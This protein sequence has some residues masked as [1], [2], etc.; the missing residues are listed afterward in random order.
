DLALDQRQA[1]AS[2]LD[3]AIA[4][5]AKAILARG[6]GLPDPDRQKV[7][8]QFLAITKKTGDAEAGKVIFKNNCAKCHKHSG[9][10]ENIGPDLTGVAVHTKEHLLVDI[11]DP[12]RNVEGNFRVWRVE[13][14]DGRSFSGMLAAETK[15]SVELV[16]AEAKRH[17][18][19]RSDIEEL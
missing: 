11:L 19:Q 6:G 1:L 13:M 10:G 16:D 9:E 2:H 7:I 3:R 18:L 17:T 14:K 15:T 12:S 4:T 8:D 5:K